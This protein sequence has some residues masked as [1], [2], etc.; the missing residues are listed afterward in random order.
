MNNNRENILPNY[1]HSIRW[2]LLFPLF[3]IIFVLVGLIITYY[4]YKHEEIHREMAFKEHSILADVLKT[5]V[6]NWLEQRRHEV[7]ILAESARMREA[8]REVINSGD[9]DG[10]AAGDALNLW[11]KVKDQYE[12]YEEIYLA[13]PATGR[14]VLSTEKGRVGTYR[15]VD[16]LLL[17]PLETNGL[18]FQDAYISYATKKPSIAF[19]YPLRWE[20]SQVPGVLVCR[21]NIYDALQP[22]L[23][24]AAAVGETGEVYLL[25]RER[26]TITDLR[27]RPNAKLEYVLDTEGSVRA[28]RGEEGIIE[29]EDYAGRTVLAAYRHIPY[30]GW[31]LVVKRDK[32]E[33]FAPVRLHTK[34]ILAISFFCIALILILSHIAVGRVTR[35]LLDLTVEA[36]EVADGNLDRQVT[37]YGQSELGILSRA[38]Q[39]MV[40]SLKEQ[41]AVER[42][43]YDKLALKNEELTAQTEE[44]TAQQEEL[45]ALS[46]QIQAQ[47]EELSAKNEELTRLNAYL[48]QADRYKS[49]FLASMSHELRTPLNAVI[50]FS[51]VLL[52]PQ[53]S[54]P[55]TAMQRSC[56]LDILEAGRFLLALIN[57]VLDLTKIEAGRVDLQYTEFFYSEVL[58]TSFTMVKEKAVKHMIEL[59]LK[60]ADDIE[61]INAD[62]RRVKQIVYN[63][64][65]N[66]VKFTPD[67][68]RVG[69]NCF[70]AATHVHTTVWDTG[71]GI[72]EEDLPRLFREFV[73]LDSSPTREYSG[74]GLGL[75]IAKKL[76][77][78]HGGAIWAESEFGRGTRFHFT[79]PLKKVER[80]LL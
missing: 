63:L 32:D 38:F 46:E 25:T 43:L 54:G 59:E 49:E 61:Y 76:V 9:T 4:I 1:F 6:E 53:I 17:K 40:K 47:A 39:E 7:T 78:L 73:Q 28:A 21:L 50:G 71:I 11:K 67:G 57:D 56:V 52:D 64:L 79:L 29:T 58:E 42:K 69:I 3:L 72:K 62:L 12:V 37:V 51:E 18:Y 13:D 44:L 48:A 75:A 22:L 36:R 23:H 15:P 5:S 24:K 55:L 35:P 30:S 45:T 70:K 68:G 20:G 31:G 2:R 41:F 65:S 10:K 14:I 77:E 66:A 19:A 26:K 33:I 74:S 16:D 8:Y 34:Q 60:V 80:K 27:L